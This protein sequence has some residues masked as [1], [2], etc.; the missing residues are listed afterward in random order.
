MQHQDALNILEIHTNPVTA[1]II[2]Q[3]YR[4]ACSKYHPDRNPAGAEMMKLV[5]IA[6]A[7]LE[8]FEGEVTINVDTQKNYGDA[9][10]TA[11]NAIIHLG[12]TLE[13]CGVWCWVSGDTKPHKEVLKAAG[14]LWS[15]KKLRWYFRPVEHKART[16]GKTWS[17]E[18]IRDAYGSDQIFRNENLRL[19]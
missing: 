12:L 16:R 10:N 14:F 4:K 15:P 1:D 5:N 11:L 6:Y 19:A 7:A 9:L 8:N 13:I 17:M 2:K 18:R 3:A